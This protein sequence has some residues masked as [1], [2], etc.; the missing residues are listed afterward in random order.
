MSPPEGTTLRGASERVRFILVTLSMLFNGFV[1]VKE[2]QCL[3]NDCSACVHP[4]AAPRWR[5]GQG[6]L[7]L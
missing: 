4:S 1:L 5:R 3:S 7:Q 2:L 6:S